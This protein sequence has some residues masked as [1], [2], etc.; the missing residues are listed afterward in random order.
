MV[1]PL[2]ERFQVLT[3]CRHLNPGCYIELLDPTN[4]VVCDDGSMPDNCALVQWNRHFLDASIKLGAPTNSAN[5]YKQQ[6]IDAG[7]INV[8]QVQ[9]KWPI[10]PWPKDPKY[11]NL[12]VLKPGSPRT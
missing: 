5:K 11:K 6:L 12:G 4:P 2:E 8:V 10:N 7:F 3:L 1:T 9:Y